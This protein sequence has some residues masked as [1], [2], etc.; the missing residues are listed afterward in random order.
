MASSFSP[1]YTVFQIHYLLGLSMFE[2]PNG[3]NND[4]AT[5]SENSVCSFILQFYN[6]PPQSLCVPP[7]R[8]R[9][10]IKYCVFS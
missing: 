4:R 6:S 5:I 2:S 3:P 9:V 7:I 1:S 10:F 8:Y